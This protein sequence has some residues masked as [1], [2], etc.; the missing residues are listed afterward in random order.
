[1]TIARMKRAIAAFVLWAYA[2]WVVGS[3]LEYAVG[4]PSAPFAALGVVMGLLAARI[5]SGRSVRPTT[6][7][8]DRLPHSD[9]RVAT[10]DG[11]GLFV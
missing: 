6:A 10:Q 5:I 4:F 11:T 7:M 1:M 2:L 9:S 8:L 3:F